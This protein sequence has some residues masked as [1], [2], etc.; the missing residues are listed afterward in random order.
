MRGSL[1]I[2]QTGVFGGDL[3]AVTT[4]G[5]V[6]RINSAGGFSQL[7]SLGVHLEGCVTVPNDAAK[8]GP[9]AGKVL[10]GA[11]GQ[12][13]IWTIDVAGGTAFYDIGIQPEDIDIIPDDANFFGVNYGSATLMGAAA[14]EFDGMEGD[15]C[16]A[17]EFPG[18][19]W[20]VRW[21]A[22]SN[23]FVKTNIA[24]VTQWE[25]VTF[26]TAG[27]LNIPPI[28]SCPQDMAVQCI[29]DIPAV[30]PSVVL[31]S[32]IP[33]CGP[34]TV[35]WSGDVV[36]GDSCRGTVTRTYT[37]T[38]TCGNIS[39][40]EQIFTYEDT[41]SPELTCPP[42]VTYQCIGEVPDCNADDATAEDNCSHTVVT[43]IREVKRGV[44][45]LEDPL[46]MYNTY[47]AT[48]ACGNT[49][50]CQE[51]IYVIDTTPPTITACPHD[52]TVSS[53]D[54]LPSCDDHTGLVATDNCGIQAITCAAEIPESVSCGGLLVGVEYVYTV[55][56]SCGLSTS[57]SRTVSFMPPTCSF[58]IDIKPRS[59][60]NPLNI[61]SG[62]A[63]IS[64]ERGSYSTMAAAEE[65]VIPV[66]ILGSATFDVHSINP[67]SVRLMG[68]PALRWAYE[69][70]AQPEIDDPT[71][72]CECTT[73]GADQFVDLS[74]KFDKAAVIAALEAAYGPLSDGQY[75]KAVLTAYTTNHTRFSGSDCFLIRG[76]KSGAA[77]ADRPD[78]LAETADRELELSAYPNP[79]NAATTIRYYAPESGSIKLTVHNI[80][81][82]LVTTLVDQHQET[83]EYSISWDA[84]TRSGQSVASGVYFYR[85]EVNGV[86][87]TRQMSLVK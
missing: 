83:G 23:A 31:C 8:Y 53:I 46:I 5:F 48:D 80:L 2:D 37:C 21:D 9:W 7:A 19:L 51:L 33:Q 38:D 43:C 82:Q 76:S 32:G 75:V 15:I 62:R 3:I 47:T 61:K 56:D 70:V 57:C 24:Q 66:A 64:K 17:Q 25:H 74:L 29:E 49:D 27:L 84:R 85:L 73:A 77:A 58:D 14:S 1:Y 41:E 35:V 12:T 60:P 71:Q 42:T 68:V 16:I 6:Y 13:R 39:V 11:E 40:C 72:D 86:A 55:T 67:S 36:Q 63:A 44:G 59:C 78:G 28:A 50:V 65:S 10:T 26:S 54:D 34:T 69:N 79:F 20:H 4:T 81:G 22:G 45:C 30:N 52:T 87:M 18:I